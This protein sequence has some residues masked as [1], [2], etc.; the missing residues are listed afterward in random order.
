MDGG[1]LSIHGHSPRP[2]EV[3]T[4]NIGIGAHAQHRQVCIHFSSRMGG[5]AIFAACARRKVALISL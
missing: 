5:A 2:Y 4:D 1:L 3:G